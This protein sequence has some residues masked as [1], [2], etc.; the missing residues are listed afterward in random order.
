MSGPNQIV[1]PNNS[2]TAGSIVHNNYSAMKTQAL[3]S[4][5]TQFFIISLFLNKKLCT[6]SLF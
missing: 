3:H 2:E 5:P 1:F 6:A 4:S